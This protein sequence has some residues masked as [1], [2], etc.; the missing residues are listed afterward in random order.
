[1]CT[2]V[3]SCESLCGAFTIALYHNFRRNSEFGGGLKKLSYNAYIHGHAGEHSKH[4][5]QTHSYHRHVI[6]DLRQIQKSPCARVNTSSKGCFFDCTFAWLVV[7]TF[8]SLADLK[9][10]SEPLRKL[11]DQAAVTSDEKRQTLACRKHLGA[12]V[13]PHKHWHQQ[14]E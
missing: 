12:C 7:G 6:Q 4:L 14:R 5:H 2:Q 3:V 11:R 8:N 10:Q 1:M 9:L 13:R